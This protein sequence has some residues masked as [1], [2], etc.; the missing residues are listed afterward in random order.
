MAAKEGKRGEDRDIPI[1]N[2]RNGKLSVLS[3]LL[4]VVVAVVMGKMRSS[5]GRDLS[6]GRPSR[7]EKCGKLPTSR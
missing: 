4:T 2:H 5:P 3:G 1:K 7:R 6:V